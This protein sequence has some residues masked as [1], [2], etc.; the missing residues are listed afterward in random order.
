MHSFSDGE[1]PKIYM[2]ILSHSDGDIFLIKTELKAINLVKYMRGIKV[3]HTQKMDINVRCHVKTPACLLI[4]IFIGLVRVGRKCVHKEII[5]GAQYRPS[6]QGGVFNL[7][8]NIWE[9]YNL[10]IEQSNLL[11]ATCR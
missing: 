2:N 5:R 1:G 10:L 6:K 11:P 8:N 4:R 3:T 7:I 9:H